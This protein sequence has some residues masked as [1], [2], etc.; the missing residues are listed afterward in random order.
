MGLFSVFSASKGSNSMSSGK[1]GNGNITSR[2]FDRDVIAHL[3]SKGFSDS[4]ADRI[5]LL[6][7]AH[8]HES[9]SSRGMDRHE[10]ERF[11][12]NLK[13]NRTDHNFSSSDIEHI[14]D[15]FRDELGQ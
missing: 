4:E 5:K 2:E 14:R 11:V 6:A 7:D 12:K 9:G 13:D 15:A 1:F 8:L 10:A 3:R